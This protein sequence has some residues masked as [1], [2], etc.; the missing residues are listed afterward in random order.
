MTATITGL[1][2]R[3]RPLDEVGPEE[4]TDTGAIHCWRA[5]DRI[6]NRDVAIRVHVPG[7]P[8]ARGWI[9][10]ALTAGGLATP[11]LA[12]VYDASEGSGGQS[13][14]A[15]VVNEWIEGQTLAER[16]QSGP[17]GEREARTVLRRLAEGVAEAHRVGLAVGGLSPETVVLR[18]NGLVGLRAVPAATGTVQE[19]IAALGALLE[20]CLTGRQA[21]VPGP[22]GVPAREPVIGAPDLA[23][24]VRRTR[25]TGPGAGLASAA[26]MAALLAE[27]PR[28]HASVP[29][30]GR[31]ESD[32]GW[33]RRLRDHRDADAAAE[34]APVVHEVPDDDPQ[35]L[36]RHTLPPVP[37][38]RARV[39]PPVSAAPA[40]A[41]DHDV[42]G[43]ADD[44]D[45]D[46]DDR[47]GRRRLMVG[48]LLLAAVALVVLLAWWVGTNLL[49]V[50]GDVDERPGSAPTGSSSAPPAEESADPSSAAGPLVA[51]TGATVFDPF[52]D[53][54]P[55]NDDEVPATIDGDPATTWST[56]SYRGSADFGNL[57][58]GVGIV[59]DLG[60][61]QAVGG[62]TLT[63]TT[64][65]IAVEVRTGGAPDGDLDSFAVAAAGS[66]DG[67]TDLAF[68]EPVTARYVLVWVTGLVPAEDGF[69][70]D[71]AEVGITT[72]S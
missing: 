47:P 9:A 69:S 52:G 68:E 8:A 49:S 41:D 60:S 62:V 26:A 58:P 51:V 11:A 72:A 12:M 43:G 53:G 23:A 22:D 57:K 10:R 5:K 63:T 4:R 7:G 1:P 31:D 33:L 15:Y 2:D 65:G 27:R 3:Y 38:G 46:D 19:D 6:L 45:E 56:L 13:G 44:Y 30:R 16:L 37:P 61:D 42:F 32:S 34:P 17:M 21:G 54:E 70:A 40:D 67:T 59:Y 28:S 36:D 64:P 20:Y 39:L 25:S 24:L 18:P 29:V 50:A 71:L 35:R 55:E 14:V 48:A 66:V